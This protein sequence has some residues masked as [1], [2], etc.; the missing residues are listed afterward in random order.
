MTATIAAADVRAGHSCCS[1]YSFRPRASLLVAPAADRRCCCDDPPVVLAA[2]RR[3][4][5]PRAGHA[6]G[7]R[8][9]DV[10]FEL[11]SRHGPQ[12]T[13]RRDRGVGVS[14]PN[15]SRRR[16]G[17]GARCGSFRRS[18]GYGWLL[19]PRRMDPLARRRVRWLSMPR[20][21]G[22]GLLVEDGPRTLFNG[23]LRSKTQ[24]WGQNLNPAMPAMEP[25]CAN[26]PNHSLSSPP[27]L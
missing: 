20:R 1:S 14:R 11:L 6:S 8:H 25:P 23:I 16:P 24:S 4:V 7:A 9:I 18:G 21:V 2:L 3:G 19:A 22:P 5:D 10:Q 27:W 17:D 13:A 12:I 26:C 15:S